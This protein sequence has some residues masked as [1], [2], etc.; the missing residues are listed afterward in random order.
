MI[1]LLMGEEMRL[2]EMKGGNVLPQEEHVFGM[3]V[4]DRE[5][6]EAID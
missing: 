5:V 6:K 2:A 4:Q 3:K 1:L